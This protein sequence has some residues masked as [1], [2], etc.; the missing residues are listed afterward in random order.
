MSS[1]PREALS[2]GDRGLIIERAAQPCAGLDPITP[3]GAVGQAKSDRRLGV[4]EP[5]EEAALHYVRKPRIDP[6]QSLQRV[7]DLEQHC[8]IV[9]RDFWSILQRN[10]SVAAAALDRQ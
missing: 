10:W 8:I 5:R 9:L 7:V 1:Y 2:Q 6:G 3:H 4:I